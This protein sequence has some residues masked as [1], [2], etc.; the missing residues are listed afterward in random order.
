MG[1]ELFP[2][3]E[4]GAAWLAVR[5][6]A[7]LADE[8]GLGKTIQA[9]SGADRTRAERVLVVCK[10]VG[11]RHWVREFEQHGQ[12]HRRAQM[13]R[14]GDTIDPTARLVVVHY[15]VLHRPE[16]LKQLIRLRFDLLLVDEMHALKAGQ[17][18]LRGQVVLDPRR[19]LAQRARSTWGLSGT[20]AP[21]HAG[22][23]HP[24]LSSLHPHLLGE[25]LAGSYDQFLQHY[26]RAEQTP[27]GWRVRGN[28]KDRIKELKG[29][30]SGV[31]LRRKRVDV[32][33]DLPPL[34]VD[35]VALDPDT[36]SSVAQLEAHPDMQAVRD[37]LL[38]LDVDEN[39]EAA[40]RAWEND[41]STLRRFTG[42]AK[43]RSMIDLLKS[44]LE[45]TDKIVVMGWHPEAL[46]LLAE[47]LREYQPVVVH[48]RTAP[49]EKEQAEEAFQTDP[50]RRVFVGNILSAGTTITLTAAHRLIF[51]ESSWVPGENEQALLRILRIGQEHP[52]EVSFAYLPDSIDEIIQS[53]AARK[54][55]MLTDFM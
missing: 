18:S 5:S 33:P 25:R 10:A 34:R 22:D 27:Y 52:C 4:E 8:M 6:R 45:G 53:V 1:L 20:P 43:V 9:V 11:R 23:L 14:P 44:E 54:A 30:L 36:R 19:G 35:T 3:Q 24:W 48:G 41:L 2:F 26:C 37:V 38:S 16:I 21:N 46:D 28:R 17:G 50:D 40:T 55:G 13:P 15:D 51:M 31:M 12:I 29:M 7:L 42:L 32:L 39:P 49:D 47:G